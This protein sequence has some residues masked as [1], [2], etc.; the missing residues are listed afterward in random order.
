MARLSS[1]T[2]LL[3]ILLTAFGFGQEQPN[4]VLMMA[5]DMC[6]DL[7][8]YGNT[9]VKT[10]HLDRLAEQGVRFDKAFTTSPVC[11]P[12]RSAIMCGVHQ[13]T[14]GAHQHRTETKLPLPDGVKTIVEYLRGAGYHTILG[15]L[16]SGKTDLNFTIE[17]DRFFHSKKWDERPKDQPFF[18]QLT[19]NNTH[20]KWGRDKERPIDPAQVEVPPYYPDHPLVRRDI[21]N[22]LEEIQI[23]DR[24]AGAVI[25]RLKKEELLE[26]TLVIF[27]GDHGRCQVRG[28]QFLYDSGLH[29]PLIMRWPGKI[30]AG[31]VRAD[32]VS[33]IDVSA[34]ILAAAGVELPDYLHGKDTLNPEQPRR[35][36][37]FAARDKMDDTHDAMRAVRSDTHKY[38]LNLMPERAYCQFNKYKENS[39]PV[40]A[41][42]N[43][44]NLKGELNPAQRAFMAPTKPEVEL[45]DL[46]NDP[47]EVH[48]LAGNAEV[49]KVEA[50]LRAELD[51]WRKRIGDQGVS[52]AFREGGWPADYPTRTLEQWEQL[53]GTW[54]NKLLHEKK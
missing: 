53:L 31:T 30:K 37:V 46:R 12:S 38:I 11:S 33:S 8:C 5:E 36:Y 7:S 24:L 10:P 21:A 34:V 16:G 23:M 19:F 51:H 25:E 54:Q 26:N 20:R 18:M 28:K 41:L 49:A 35:R 15:G 3:A 2:V 27:I 40:L 13:N 47:F 9:S 45:Y 14:I 43:V 17:K 48:N 52:A 1:L 42:L 4:I 32:L 29:V 6:P 39:Y 22:G 44:M 50:E